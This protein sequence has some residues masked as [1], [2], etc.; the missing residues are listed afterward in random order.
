MSQDVLALMVA[1]LQREAFTV[2]LY[3]ADAR[4]LF[5]ARCGQVLE[6]IKDPDARASQAV[7]FAMGLALRGVPGQLVL[8][9]WG[10]R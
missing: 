9:K 5:L 7:N 6:A 3:D 2:P 10:V 8:R 1:E 4:E